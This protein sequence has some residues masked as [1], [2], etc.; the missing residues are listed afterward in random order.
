M[1]KFKT[2]SPC[3]FATLLITATM[4]TAGCGNSTKPPTDDKAELKTETDNAKQITQVFVETLKGE[5]QSAMK[6]GG[7]VNALTVCN[8]KA[9]PVTATVASE[10]GVQLSRVSLKNRNPKNVPNDWQK[11]VLTDFDTRAANGEDVKIMAYSK[12]V[13]ESGKREFRFMKALP[14]GGICLT[15]HGGDLPVDVSAKLTELYPQD[16]ATG[17]N[18]GQVRG[19]IVIVKELD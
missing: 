14:T 2:L 12:I 11:I 8:I 13:T 16:K 1:M 5:L 19:A 17:Y 18:I 6:A 9:L 4:F 7:P 15:C 3:L 10:Q